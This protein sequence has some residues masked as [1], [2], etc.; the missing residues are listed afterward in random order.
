M[1]KSWSG[2]SRIKKIYIFEI[3]GTYAV[4]I[5]KTCLWFIF[6]TVLYKECISQHACSSGYIYYLIFASFIG[7][8][9]IVLFSLIIF[10]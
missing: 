5:Q 4:A 9:L 2:I 1:L 3:S 7:K 10:W 6:P 8:K